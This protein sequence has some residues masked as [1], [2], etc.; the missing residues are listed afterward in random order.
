MGEETPAGQSDPR[1]WLDP[2]PADADD[3]RIKAYRRTSNVTWALLCA[4]AVLLVT[5]AACAVL[6]GWPEAGDGWLKWFRALAAGTTKLWST[7]CSCFGLPEILTAVLAIATAAVFV[8]LSVLPGFL[9]LGRLYFWFVVNLI[10]LVIIILGLFGVYILWDQVE[11][12]A[13]V[14]DKTF[15]GFEKYK[16]REFTDLNVDEKEELFQIGETATFLL[17]FATSVLTLLYIFFTNFWMSNARRRNTRSWILYNLMNRMN[18]DLA[19]LEF[20]QNRVFFPRGHGQEELCFDG[21]YKQL[22]K[23]PAFSIALGRTPKGAKKAITRLEDVPDDYR[24]GADDLDDNEP[25][26][27]ALLIPD[28][29]VELNQSGHTESAKILRAMLADACNLL[30]GFVETWSND[31]VLSSQ[32]AFDFALLT[33]RERRL[34]LDYFENYNGLQDRIKVVLP[35]LKVA[36][37]YTAERGGACPKNAE[38]DA[39]PFSARNL[40]RLERIF[41]QL[42]RRLGEAAALEELYF[43]RGGIDGFHVE[44]LSVAVRAKK[45]G[46]NID[47]IGDQVLDDQREGRRG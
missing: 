15:D 47:A 13:A 9:N 17:A 34:A 11:T 28:V 7:D 8:V 29:F 37:G 4:L 19:V 35:F 22:T 41:V 2:Q 30:D 31:D 32:I 3:P 43:R 26:I 40:Y 18:Q 23:R 5:L 1:E 16:A 6:R 21:I 25:D 12:I 45:R 38:T 36:A 44:A 46:L 20:V 42:K 27:Q 14:A 39:Q 10:Y 33:Y 24:G